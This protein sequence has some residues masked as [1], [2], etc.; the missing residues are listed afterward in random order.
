MKNKL[1]LAANGLII[2][3]AKALRNQQT[4]AEAL[5][6]GHLSKGN[7]FGVKFR[8]QHAISYYIADFYCHSNKLIIELDG[9]IHNLPE[10]VNNDIERQ[11]YLESL[12]LTVLRFKNQEIFDNLEQVLQI[13]KQHIKTA[14]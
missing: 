9:S 2:Q 12:G 14:P 11:Q 1:L 10:V 7:Q 3:N 6:W 13:I 5:L 8:R 4:P